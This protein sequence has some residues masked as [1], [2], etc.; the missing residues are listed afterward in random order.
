M[1]LLC[2]V[3]WREK[4]LYVLI[5]A[6]ALVLLRNMV[7]G[8]IVS[9][10]FRAS[11]PSLFTSGALRQSRYSARWRPNASAPHQAY[12]KHGSDNE[13][14]CKLPLRSV[15]SQ[16]W[17]TCQSQFCHWR[18]D[19]ATRCGEFVRF[20]ILRPAKPDRTQRNTKNTPLHCCNAVSLWQH[21]PVS[22]I[23]VI[24]QRGFSAVRCISRLGSRV[25]SRITSFSARNRRALE[26]TFGLRS[27]PVNACLG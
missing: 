13:F 23:V 2:L 11:H 24:C 22:R 21:V 4:A 5:F 14:R 25:S 27:L 7:L 3:G 20:G 19:R 6:C 12:P 9:R 10:Y 1:L 8:R 16:T 18:L 26:T 17:Q 15:C